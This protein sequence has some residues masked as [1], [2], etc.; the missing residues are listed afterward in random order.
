MKSRKIELISIIR[1]IL[2]KTVQTLEEL[3]LFTMFVEIWNAK[4]FAANA[5]YLIAKCFVRSIFLKRVTSLKKH[6]M[7]ATTVLKRSYVLKIS[8][9]TAQ[10][11]QMQLCHVEDQRAV[12]ACEYPMSR[13][14]KWMN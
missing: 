4:A 14:W 13:S 5:K 8:M 11:M 7:F 1:I 6:H 12:K 2:V 9:Y 10:S 3:M